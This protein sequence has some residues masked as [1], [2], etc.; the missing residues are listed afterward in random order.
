VDSLGHTLYRFD[1][2]A[3]N[4]SNCSG[5]CAQ[6]WPPL[7][8]P[9]GNPT[10]PPGLPGIL[11]IITR[12]DGGRQVTYNGLPLYTYAQD[13][14]PGDTNGEGVGGVWHVVHPTDMAPP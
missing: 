8:L 3:R 7:L 2:D 10:G 6:A 9:I 4:T 1:L 5:G 12:A 13:I 11:A 14:Q